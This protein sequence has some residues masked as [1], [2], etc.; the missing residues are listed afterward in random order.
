MLG[1]GASH[2]RCSGIG[3]KGCQAQ[4]LQVPLPMDFRHAAKH[5]LLMPRCRQLAP[6]PQRLP[7]RRLDLPMKPEMRQRTRGRLGGSAPCSER[8]PQQL[9]LAVLAG[10]LILPMSGCRRR[11]SRGKLAVS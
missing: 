4:L 5:S 9:V 8:G 6:A 10:R 7:Q 2:S 11:G 1:A 3:C